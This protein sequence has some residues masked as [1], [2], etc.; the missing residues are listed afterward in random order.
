VS[1]GLMWAAYAPSICS[2][3]RDNQSLYLRS[4]RSTSIGCLCRRSAQRLLNAVP[5]DGDPLN[6][7]PYILSVGMGVP[8][9]KLHEK[10]TPGDPS[11]TV[12][13]PIRSR[14]LSKRFFDPVLG[15]FGAP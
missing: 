13:A 2:A 9:A 3:L 15:A 8:P 5:D 7:G 1:T 10:A 4:V 12:G 11:L 6:L 14:A